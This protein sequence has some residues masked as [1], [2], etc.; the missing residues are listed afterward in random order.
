MQTLSLGSGCETIGIVIH[1]FLH[2]IGIYHEQSRADRDDYV[3]IL[4]ENIDS[5][6]EMVFLYH[7]GFIFD[8]TY[9]HTR[10]EDV[11]YFLFR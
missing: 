5:G 3:T 1:E 11:K 10:A 9:V 8:L 7:H 2:A 4:S 6:Y